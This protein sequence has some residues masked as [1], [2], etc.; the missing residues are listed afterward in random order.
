VR[1]PLSDLLVLAAELQVPRLVA[2]ST[3]GAAT[4]VAF[5]G[6]AG[7][8]PGFGRFDPCDWGLGFELRD[9][10]TPHWTGTRNG[11]ATFGHFGQSGAFVWVDPDAG[12]ACAAACDRAFG[13]WA[14]T[15]WPEL[16]DAVLGYPWGPT[17]APEHGAPVP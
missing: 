1:G 14:T 5:P 2:A 11:S 8:L 7:V 6:L 9:A 15:A 13:P 17:A 10:K 12:L 4:T 16:A 3:L